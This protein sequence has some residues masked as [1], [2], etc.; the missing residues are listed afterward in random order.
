MLAA[1]GQGG[2]GAPPS[3]SPSPSPLSPSPEALLLRATEC[4]IC[5]DAPRA[6][7]FLPCRHALACGPCAQVR[8]RS[9]AG[10]PYLRGGGREGEGVYTAF[11]PCRHAL[12]C[13]PCAQVRVP[14]GPRSTRS[15]LGQF[16][17]ASVNED[18]RYHSRADTPPCLC[19]GA[20][21]AR[22]A[23]PYLPRSGRGCHPRRRQ[24]RHVRAPP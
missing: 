17:R 8:A 22:H 11:L 16:D 14:K 7:A 2:S 1:L 21:A 13:G 23:L 4:R 5:M 12:A 10:G 24:R 19:P 15:S 6:T 3:A 20:A 18:L 9:G